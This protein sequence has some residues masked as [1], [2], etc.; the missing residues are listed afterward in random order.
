MSRKPMIAGNWKMFKTGSEAAL[1]AKRLAQLSSDVNYTDIMIAPSFT[2]LPLVSQALSKS[3]VKTGAQNLYFETQGAF[4]GEVSAEMIKDAG[5]DYV[6]IGHSE[7]RLFFHETDESICKKIRAALDADII[8]LMCV[9]ETETQKK[10]KKTFNVLDKQIKDGLKGFR[11]DELE[12]LVLAY[13]PVW[14]IGTGLTATPKQANEIHQYLRD[15][16]G[17]MFGKTLAKSIRILYGG[18]VKPDNVSELMALEDVDGCLVGG[19]S[20]DP[21]IFIQ[22]IKFRQT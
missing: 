16:I 13:E 2:A 14:A 5:A 3:A 6:I 18:S 8:P 12:R 7:R 17:K 22:V 20:L 19:A 1:S 4:T 11:S 15:R 10:E 9:G 21:E